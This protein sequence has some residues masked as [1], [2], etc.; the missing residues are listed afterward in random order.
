[1]RMT[2][3]SNGLWKSL[4]KNKQCPSGRVHNDNASKSWHSISCIIL[5]L[6]EAINMSKEE[7]KA[8]RKL[9]CM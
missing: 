7:L 4:R 1:M 3:A 2:Q 9:M 5:K 6:M 8:N